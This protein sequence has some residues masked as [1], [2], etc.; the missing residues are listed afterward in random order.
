MSQSN[1]FENDKIDLTTACVKLAESYKEESMKKHNK[2]NSNLYQSIKEF[3]QSD[4]SLSIVYIGKTSQNFNQRMTDEDLSIF[5]TIFLDFAPYI[6]H[7]D[8]SNN[9]ITER[10]MNDFF[11]LLSKCYGLI[12][13]NLQFNDLF[14]T[15]GKIL[16]KALIQIHEDTG[17]TYLEYL[18]L[19]GCR[20]TSEGLLEISYSDK[21]YFGKKTLLERFFYATTNLIELNLSENDIDEIGLIELFSL[22]L[23]AKIKSSIRILSINGSYKLRFTEETAYQL[24]KVLKANK[25]L[26]KL[27]LKQVGLKDESVAIILKELQENSTLRV[28]DLSG[29]RISYKGCEH[30][31]YY[32]K[33]PSCI[34]QS[35]ILNNN[36][37]GDYSAKFIIESIKYNESLAH[38]DLNHNNL[39]ETSLTKIAEAICKNSSLASVNVFWNEF[40]KESIKLFYDI[41][42]DDN[43]A[44]RFDFMIDAY[45]DEL[46]IYENDE[47]LPYNIFVKR[48]HFI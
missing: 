31:M 6:K 26:E 40:N 39:T 28:L 16:L 30:L 32:L 23:P 3:V 4:S 20:I 46:Q 42:K 18:N 45:R 36:S 15:G 14:Q 5:S 17:E 11:K 35:L 47:P 25:K 48:E 12:S 19:E 37:I 9:L 21:L 27:S 10:S 22:L 13:L 34:L 29:N 7:I 41:I 1:N 44:F 38:I 24:S 33:Y 43:K 8:L 2:F